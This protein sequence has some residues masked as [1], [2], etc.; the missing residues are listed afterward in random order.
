VIIDESALEDLAVG[1]A[2]LGSG[3][4]GDPYVGKLMAREALRECGPVELVELDD[5]DDDALVVAAA[6]MGAPG[7]MV[8][9]IPNGDEVVRAVR[10]LG[11]YLGRPVK[12]VMSGEVGGLNSMIPVYA[13]ARIGL[14][15]VDADGTGRAFPEIHMSTYTIHGISATPLAIA[16]EHG[17]TVIVDAVDNRRAEKLARGITV[18]MGAVALV[19]AYPATAA[20]LREAVVRGTI[21]RAGRIGAA[22]RSARQ[23]DASPVETAREAVGGTSVFEGKVVEVER[24]T[25]RGFST[26]HASLVGVEGYAGMRLRLDFQ[27]EFLAARL[28]DVFVVTTPDLIT[29]LDVEDG[30]PIPAEALRYGARVAVIAIPCPA[31]WRSAAGLALAGPRA[32][33]Y[34]VE[35]SAVEEGPVPAP[36][37]TPASRD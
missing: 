24:R 4:G 23:R 30:T 37:E 16:D 1:A 19:A 22:I 21:G 26:G 15:L 34:D 29:A 31:V 36:P 6:M 18:D 14:P 25:E 28:D 5:L 33:G 9:K 11:A 2:L 32:F 8:E 3:G 13:A 17:D 10:S 20:E 7:V 35:Y 27:N 12:A